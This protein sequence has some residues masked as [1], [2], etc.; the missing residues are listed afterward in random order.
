MS[1]AI[2]AI[3]ANL[4]SLLCCGAAAY[5]AYYDKPNWGWF[6]VVGLLCATTV[7][8]RKPTPTNSTPQ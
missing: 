7:N 1:A 6:L 4:V 3:S 8:F 2:V 5:L